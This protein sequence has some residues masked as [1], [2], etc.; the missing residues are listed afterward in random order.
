MISIPDC[1]RN[2]PS[3]DQLLDWCSVHDLQVALD[4]TFT[5]PHLTGVYHHETGT[6]YLARSLPQAW[7]PATLAHEIIHAHNTHDGHQNQT[8]EQRIDEA[9]AKAIIDPTEY[10]YWEEQYGWRTGGIAKEL[11][12]PRWVVEAYRRYLAK[13]GRVAVA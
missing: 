6:I 11:D 8:I 12:Q 4:Y 3:L 7:R 5:N 10:A 2:Q 13:N 1:I 9:V